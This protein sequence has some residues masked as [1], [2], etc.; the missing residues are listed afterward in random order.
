[1][2]LLKQQGFSLLEVMISMLLGSIM[3]LAAVQVVVNS[4][5]TFMVNESLVRMAESGNYALDVIGNEVRMA[6][7]GGC[8]E[9]S[10]G[11]SNLLVGKGAS[12]QPERGIQ[13]WEASN[14]FF[15]ALTPSH[16][17]ESVMQGSNHWSTTQSN[18]M[19]QTSVQASK[20]SDIIRLWSVE[21]HVFDF[22]SYSF[23][24]GMH[25]ITVDNS[26][27]FPAPIVARIL[28]VSDCNTV[29]IVMAVAFDKSTR[30]ITLSGTASNLQMLANMDPTKTEVGILKGVQFYLKQRPGSIGV[31]VVSLYR[32]YIQADGGLGSSE[33]LVE[34]IA[35]MQIQYGENSSGSDN[36]VNRYVS[37]ANVINW[38]NVL[39]VR[40]WLLTVSNTTFAGLEQQPYHYL[41]HDYTS[42]DHRFRR[43]VSMTFSLRNRMA[44]DEQ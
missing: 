5:K 30:N 33:E 10:Q 12:I 42:S 4:K 31:P 1:M 3:L 26:S 38:T 13:G 35:N 8:R 37:A 2:A 41:R 39:S 16:W 27:N 36:S 24:N 20:G 6:G 23:S 32:Q 18:F 44:G 25:H 14:T 17:D 11:V 34:G 7:Y 28:M 21:P 15:G 22:S 19:P 40:I 9:T 29:A 43:E